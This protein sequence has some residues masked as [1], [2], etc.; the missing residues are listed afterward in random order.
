MYRIMIFV[1]D[2]FGDIIYTTRH[3]AGYQKAHALE[4]KTREINKRAMNAEQYGT[5]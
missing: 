1:A 3:G 5:S 2:E 4:S